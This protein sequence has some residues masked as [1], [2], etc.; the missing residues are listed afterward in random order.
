MRFGD[1]RR[2]LEV[3]EM[4]VTSVPPPNAP[5][6]E[7]MGGALP[8][9]RIEPPEGWVSLRLGELWEYRELIYFLVWRD[10]KVRYKQTALGAAW[11]PLQPVPILMTPGIIV[12]VLGR[13]GK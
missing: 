10:I 9:L 13:R 6:V 11:V 5:A 8:A 4:I 2:C 7:K 1:V 12:G 3:I